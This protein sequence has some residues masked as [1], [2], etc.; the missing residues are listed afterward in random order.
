M[1]VRGP[2]AAEFVNATLTNDLGRIEPG[3]AQYTLCCDESGGVVDDLIAYLFGR[4][5]SSWCRTQ[6]MPPRCCA[7]SRRRRRPG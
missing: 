3:K 7:G 2:G 1:T 6:P 5:R 4:S